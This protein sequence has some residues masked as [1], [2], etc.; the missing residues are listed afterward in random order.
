MVALQP[1]GDATARG[2]ACG[3]E[4]FFRDCDAEAFV[5]HCGGIH[6]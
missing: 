6:Y 5:H 1:E 3:G 4:H 2:D